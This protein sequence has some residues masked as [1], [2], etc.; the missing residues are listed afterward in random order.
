M[1][2]VNRRVRRQAED[3]AVALTAPLTWSETAFSKPYT[4]PAPLTGLSSPTMSSSR[5]LRK[6]K[7][8]QGTDN[9]DKNEDCA[10]PK[11]TRK[12]HTVDKCNP[13]DPQPDVP[14]A[15]GQSPIPIR[16]DI[17]VTTRSHTATST[18]KKKFSASDQSLRP[19]ASRAD[20]VVEENQSWPDLDALR[21]RI[22]ELEEE[23]TDYHDSLHKETEKAMERGRQ[24]LLLQARAAT[25][26]ERKD[27]TITRQR[28]SINHKDKSVDR[29]IGPAETTQHHEPSTDQHIPSGETEAL[30]ELSMSFSSCSA[31]ESEL[32]KQVES[33]STRLSEAERE[34]EYR[35]AQ[36]LKL[37]K[38]KWQD[39]QFA[40]QSRLMRKDD[41]KLAQ[42]TKEPTWG[43]GKAKA[44][45]E[46]GPSDG[47]ESPRMSLDSIKVKLLNEKNHRL[48]EKLRRCYAAGS[49]LQTEVRE[50]RAS[51]E[52]TIR[53][54]D[55]IATALQDANQW[56]SREKVTLEDRLQSLESNLA[57]AYL[58]IDQLNKE[59]PP[60]TPL[61]ILDESREILARLQASHELRQRI[62]VEELQS[63]RSKNDYLEAEKSSLVE[64]LS[65]LKERFQTLDLNYSESQLQLCTAESKIIL[66]QRT[67]QN[68][69]S[70]VRDTAKKH[71]EDVNTLEVRI[72]ELSESLNRATTEVAKRDE[73]L[74]TLRAAC[75]E[76]ERLLQK[77]QE[78]HE[79]TAK[80]LTA[81]I[82]EASKADAE[83]ARLRHFEYA[84]T[85]HDR[86]VKR[87]EQGREEML[88]QQQERLAA[89]MEARRQLILQRDQNAELQRGNEALERRVRDLETTKGEDEARF[90][91]F[92]LSVETQ[93]G[94]QIEEP[95]GELGPIPEIRRPDDATL[96]QLGDRL[97]EK[98][99]MIEYELK[100]YRDDRARIYNE[101]RLLEQWRNEM[102]R[103]VVARLGT[104]TGSRQPGG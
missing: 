31:L 43:A 27:G 19:D 13:N 56:H 83:V 57:Q 95:G 8:E 30:R 46:R 16:S 90:T 55:D 41:Y 1:R 68:L 5:A 59:K 80:T 36:V 44:L 87:L 88:R 94:R 49:K 34:I 21:S 63:S 86:A 28:P 54:R 79:S 39:E 35:V 37:F 99:D 84:V 98:L 17:G 25:T 53:S 42:A 48:L 3:S 74:C 81:K 60:M 69:E 23:R 91:Q 58:N 9:T 89:L 85:E 47:L 66:L 101:Y 11:R 65:E 32:Q 102:A 7:H 51:L 72:K 38:Y 24:L 50:L 2:K 70:G 100:W 73:D 10:A 33:L 18:K 103:N 78:D 93:I 26:N 22:Q 75:L 29:I 15:Q 76:K 77:A 82:C 6:R 52:T 97:Q 12:V 4:G 14:P 61:Q 104:I 92:L 96:K 45:L 62:L 64:N 71:A 67:V 40:A 20:A